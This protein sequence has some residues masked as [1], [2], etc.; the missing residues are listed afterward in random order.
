LLGNQSVNQQG[1]SIGNNF[2]KKIKHTI[3]QT[4]RS[5]FL[6]LFCIIL[7]GDQSNHS[8]IQ[9]IYIYIQS[10][11]IPIIKKLKVTPLNNFSKSLENKEG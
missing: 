6:H 9:S 10:I 5:K 11:I 1:E 7:F 2:G 4:Y 8:K 3:Q